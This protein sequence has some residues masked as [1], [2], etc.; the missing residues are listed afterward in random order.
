MLMFLSPVF[1]PERGPGSQAA[2]PVQPLGHVIDSPRPVTATA[3][4]SV[5]GLAL[6]ISLAVAILG[7]FFSSTAARSSPMSSDDIAISV[8][9]LGK[10]TSFRHPAI[11]SSNS[12]RWG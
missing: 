6:V 7:N 12:S 9:N 1:Y 5:W 8:R 2:L 3:A 11:A 10:T 4:W